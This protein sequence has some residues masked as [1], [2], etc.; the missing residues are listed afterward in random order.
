MELL[1][2]TDLAEVIGGQPVEL[3]RGL[4]YLI[5]ATAGLSFAHA[6]GIVHRDI[7]PANFFI[8][9]DDTVKV[10]DFGIAKRTAQAAG[11]TQTGFIA[12]T[13]SYMS[14]EQINNFATVSHLTDLYAL[15]VV[16][17]EV[18]TGTVPFEHEEL[19]KLLMMHITEQALPPRARNPAIPPE[20]EQLIL[21]L[22]EKDPANRIQS[23]RELGEMLGAIADFG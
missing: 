19:V 17:Y 20:L 9:S 5:Q 23:C 12:G 3:G 21:R 7:K 18:F 1:H 14:P 16:A 10:M 15:G 11:L 2:G 22:L 4:R 8:T 6:K 13:P